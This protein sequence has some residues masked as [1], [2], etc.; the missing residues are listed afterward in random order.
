MNPCK[1]CC[2]LKYGHGYQPKCEDECDYAK[3]VRGRY[4]YI[5]EKDKD[6]TNDAYARNR[7]LTAVKARKILLST[8][9][10]VYDFA[11]IMSAE[12]MAAKTMEREIPRARWQYRCGTC[13]L[14]I[15]ECDWGDE[16]AT[17]G[18]LGQFNYCPRCGQRIDWKHDS[19]FDRYKA[20]LPSEYEKPEKVEKLKR[21]LDDDRDYWNMQDQVFG[22]PRWFFNDEMIWA[23]EPVWSRKNEVNE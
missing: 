16:N 18:E 4:E 22:S 5:P 1:D 7:K 14:D 23:E 10:T 11:D 21:R 9:Q 3:A 12:W 15:S 17:L 6:K 13:D 20:M 19:L 8:N 2:F